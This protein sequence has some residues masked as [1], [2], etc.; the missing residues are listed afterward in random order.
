MSFCSLPL[1]ENRGRLLPLRTFN[2]EF[3]RRNNQLRALD[4]IT[5]AGQEFTPRLPEWTLKTA[6]ETQHW[7]SDAAC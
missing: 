2:Q 4:S 7:D 3:I 1:G 6:A 5:V